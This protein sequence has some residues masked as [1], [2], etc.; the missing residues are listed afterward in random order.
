[1]QPTTS[2]STGGPS[3]QTLRERFGA[4]RRDSI[5]FFVEM[6]KN[7]DVSSVDA[8]E[9]TV[10]LFNHPD[11]VRDVLVTNHQSFVKAIGID[12][13]K[14]LLGEG[15]LT[16]EGEAHR[17]QRR[18]AQPAFHRQRIAGY[19]DTMVAH[20]ALWSENLAANGATDIA[21]EMM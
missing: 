2:N 5:G 8:G 16:A 14:K 9:R 17:T 3:S 19:A 1:M 20:A 11:L 12:S 10:F 13:V 15:M 4:F 7:G 21:Q 18:L 6:A